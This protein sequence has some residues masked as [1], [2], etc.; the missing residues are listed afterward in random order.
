MIYLDNNA[1]TPLDPRVKEV[2]LQELDQFHGNPSSVHSYGQ[3]A[4]SLLTKARRTIAA[5]LHVKPHEI[6]FTSGATEGMNMIL[7]G[8]LQK[9]DHLIT[10]AVEH[11][12]AYE[13]AR[14]LESAGVAVTYLPVGLR[15]SVDLEDVRRA[16][17]P[18]TRLIALLSVNNETG[19]KNDIEGI[20]Q[21]ASE[22]KIHF[23]I[24][25]VAHLGKEAMT[26]P[27]GVSAAC[28]SGHKI[29]AP[30]G[31][32][33]VF[34]RHKVKLAPLFLGGVQEFQKRGG[35]ENLLGAIALS[36]AVRLLHFELPQ[37]SERIRFLRDKFERTLME[38]LEDVSINGNGPRVVNTS[39]LAFKGVDGES[40][41]AHL[42]LAGV[43][44]SH[45]SACSAG[46]LEP[47]RV[48]LQMGLPAETAA[49][50]IRFSLSR[51]TQ[52]EEIDKAALIII[53]CVTKLRKLAFH[54][55]APNF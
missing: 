19:V 37:A 33:F 20:A 47:S 17:R 5:Y 4:K 2:I 46:A 7:R 54:S 3:A 13:T 12:A 53:D 1:T 32:G 6:L 22:H 26:L 9:G 25:G 43:A 10:S 38:G 52:E 44:A 23:L 31:I 30:Q 34:L 24:D 45:G 41:L 35:T 51:M 42:D 50:S 48:L 29:H 15:G 36:E 21:V 55:D 49:A 27:S 8:L 14:H 40:L 28:F 39:N 16:I 18:N 11:P